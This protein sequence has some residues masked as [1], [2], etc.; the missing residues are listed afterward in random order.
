MKKR[1]RLFYNKEF[2]DW[3]CW[4]VEK[5]NSDTIRL[6]YMS[7]FTDNYKRNAITWIPQRSNDLHIPTF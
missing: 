4:L 2:N 7:W 1:Y 3:E 6:T 5:P